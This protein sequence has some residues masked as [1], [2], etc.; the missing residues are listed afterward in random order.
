MTVAGQA[1]LLALLDIDPAVEG[2]F[3]E[4]YS[5][6]HMRDRVVGLPGFR[7]GRRFESVGGNPRYAALYEAE[8]AETFTSEAYLSLIRDPDENSR[9]YL[10]NFIGPTRFMGRLLASAGEGEGGTAGF[11]L[12]DAGEGRTDALRQWLVE[13]V[14]GFAAERGVIAAHA[15]EVAADLVAAS[16]RLHLRQTPDHVP[17]FVVLVEATNAAGITAVDRIFMGPG[18]IAAH[19]GTTPSIAGNYQMVYRVAP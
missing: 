15:W 13:T 16:K 3:N 10:P 9:R 14:P 12:F 6:E 1:I 8:R 4:W 18:G 7:R 19:G 17:G 2:E 11:Y 5:R